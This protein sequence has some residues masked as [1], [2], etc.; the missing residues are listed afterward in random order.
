VDGVHKA[1]KNIAV[2][3]QIHRVTYGISSDPLMQF[4]VVFS[5]L[6]HA[7][8]NTGLTELIKMN[9]PA[10]VAYREESVAEQNSVDTQKLKQ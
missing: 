5:A 7:V 2:A 8:D 1:D 4:S 6:I 9:T 3:E 10:A